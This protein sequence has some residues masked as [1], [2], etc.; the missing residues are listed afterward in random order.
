R[1]A[2]TR[3]GNARATLQ[4]R[5]AEL[6]QV[7]VHLRTTRDGLVATISAH[8]QVGHDALQQAGNELRRSLED[9]GVQLH[10]LDL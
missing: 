1:I 9:K 10:S 6:G 2:T 3:A 8:D 7:D 5:P 4:L